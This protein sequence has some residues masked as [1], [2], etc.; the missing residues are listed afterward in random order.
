MR[1]LSRGLT[2]CVIDE[3]TGGLFYIGDAELAFVAYDSIDDTWHTGAKLV[4]FD[5]IRQ[6]MPKRRLI[7]GSWRR[8]RQ[9]R[10]C[11]LYPLTGC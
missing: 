3:E 9:M 5:V 6:M 7:L 10:L 11:I 8:W 4:G 2:L 1:A